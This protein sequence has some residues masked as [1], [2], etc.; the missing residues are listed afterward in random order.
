MC[1]PLRKIS[2]FFTVDG[3]ATIALDQ[4]MTK[5]KLSDVLTIKMSDRTIKIQV[6][7]INV[8]FLKPN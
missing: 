4:P 6:P 5:H 7:R 1:P 8:M 3:K 2:Y